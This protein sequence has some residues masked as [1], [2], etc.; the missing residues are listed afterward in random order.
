M[1]N[2][3]DEAEAVEARARRNHF[4]IATNRLV[5][6]VLIVLGM[7]IVAGRIDMQQSIGWL[8]VVFGI[9]DFFVFPLILARRYR[10]PP[11]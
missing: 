1:D 9:F 4:M 11:E 8:L 10:T 2:P 7:L 3:R 6:A 5:G